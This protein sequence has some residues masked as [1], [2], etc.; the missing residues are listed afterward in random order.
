VIHAIADC[1]HPLMC[2][3]GPSVVSQK[4]A[5]SGSFQQTLVSICNGVIVWRLI[6]KEK[7]THT[8]VFLL[9]LHVV[10]DLYLGYSELLD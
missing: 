1:E 2:L 7:S 5:I 3:L 6:K 10:C 4:T 8:F 9:E